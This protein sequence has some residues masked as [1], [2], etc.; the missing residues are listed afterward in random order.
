LENIFIVSRDQRDGDLNAW[1][2]LAARF[3]F[4][5]RILEEE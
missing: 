3:Y 1:R 4:W 5:L 2:L